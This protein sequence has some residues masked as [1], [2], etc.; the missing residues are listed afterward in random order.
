MQI[1]KPSKQTKNNKMYGTAWL[2][3]LITIAGIKGKIKVL[4]LRV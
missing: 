2:Q 1:K 4:V 3:G